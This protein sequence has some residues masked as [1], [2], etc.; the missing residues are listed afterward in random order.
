M[1]DLS[2][3]ASAKYWFEYLD[4]MIYR[5]ITFMES[6]ENW[7]LDGNPE[8][9]DA[10]KQLG[11]ELDDIEKID[12][13]LL[14]EEDKF[15][16][17]VGNIKSGRGLRLLQA[18]DTVHPGSASRVLIHAEETS[19]SSNDPAGFFLKRNIVFERLR[20]LSRV[21]CQYRLK[22]VLRALEGDE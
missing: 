5:V 8:L 1:P 14:A 9:E 13:G 16:R 2:H 21:F 3:E 4:P 15:I 7:T 18:I 11:Q 17:I 20:L 6:V 22:L 12:L 10:M 19:L